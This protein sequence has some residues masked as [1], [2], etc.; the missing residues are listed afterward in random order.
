[1][2]SLRFAWL[3]ASGAG[4][5]ALATG[6]ARGTA[7]GW[8]FGARAASEKALGALREGSVR[9]GALTPPFSAFAGSSFGESCETFVRTKSVRSRV[10]K[11]KCFE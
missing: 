5:S 7:F 2:S 6:C 1:M 9:R 11:D 4:C 10:G 3:V 8:I